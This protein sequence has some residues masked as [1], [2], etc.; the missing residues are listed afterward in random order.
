MARPA[1]VV[2]NRDK[3][4]G[5]EGEEARHEDEGPGEGGRPGGGTGD[6]PLVGYLGGLPAALAGMGR[7]GPVGAPL[8]RRGYFSGFPSSREAARWA[9]R[10]SGYRP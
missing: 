5:D 9:Q 2:R 6:R 4:Q 10:A 1:G 8:P 7:P 3:A